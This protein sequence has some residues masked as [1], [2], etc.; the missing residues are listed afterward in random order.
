MTHDVR[1]TP[2]DTHRKDAPNDEIMILPQARFVTLCERLG[3]LGVGVCLCG[4]EGLI[5]EGEA[6]EEPHE[7]FGCGA[8][9]IGLFVLDKELESVGLGGVGEVS[10]ADF[11]ERAMAAG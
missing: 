11:L 4:V 1:S 9:F 8:F 10:G 5:G 7:A 3:Q 2:N 6:T